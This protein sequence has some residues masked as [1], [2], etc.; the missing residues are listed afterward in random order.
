ME[1]QMK[2]SGGQEEI[3]LFLDKM[4]DLLLEEILEEEKLLIELFS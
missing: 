2:L 1:H 3:E 4:A